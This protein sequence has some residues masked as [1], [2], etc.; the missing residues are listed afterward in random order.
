M[1]TWLKVL[2]IIGGLFVVLVLV[3]VV[4]GIYALK[5]YG[6]EMVEAGKQTF[7]EAEEYGR[8]TDNEGCLNEAIAR[9]NR[10]DGFKDM[11]KTNLF[12]RICLERSRPTQGFCDGVPLQT[13]FIKSAQWQMQQCGRYNLK[14][15]KQCG[16]LFQQV[17]QFCDPNRQRPPGI[18][19]GSS[20][21]D[22]EPPPPPPPAPNKR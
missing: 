21:S 14:A 12:L 20:N 17:Q 7:A 3:T 16:Q 15:E 22:A 9:H 10:S 5:K 11:I 6:P 19:Y 8:R 1:P 13:E 4:A 18:S 2:L